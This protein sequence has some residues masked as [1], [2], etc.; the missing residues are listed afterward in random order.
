[1]DYDNIK[2]L[3]KKISKLIFLNLRRVHK[4]EREL[5]VG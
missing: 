4:R 3:D 1:M 5:E 2:G